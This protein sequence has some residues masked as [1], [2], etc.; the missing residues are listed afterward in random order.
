MRTST[1][2]KAYRQ[3]RVLD[4]LKELGG[5]CKTEELDILL[6]DELF[7]LCG[8][9]RLSGLN[10]VLRELYA[11]GKVTAA[12][13]TTPKG[14]TY[15]YSYRGDEPALAPV[16]KAAAPAAKIVLGDRITLQGVEWVR[17][18][19]ISVPVKPPE[20]PVLYRAQIRRVAPC[21][22]L[23]GKHLEVTLSIADG[24]ERLAPRQIVEIRL[25]EGGL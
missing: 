3:K 14:K 13:V 24:Y 10:I 5:P 2:L 21:D 23:N 18:D 9:G 12:S 4:T 19:T 7:P 11:L 8:K 15:V 16:V 17:A 20:Q 1:A 25:T 6:G 22:T